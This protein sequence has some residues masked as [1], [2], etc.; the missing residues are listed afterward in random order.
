MTQRALLNTAG[1][2]CLLAGI[3]QVAQIRS[4]VILVLIIAAFVCILAGREQP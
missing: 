4:G 3:L 1:V 2:L